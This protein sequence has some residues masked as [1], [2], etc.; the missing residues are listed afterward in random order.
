MHANFII[1]IRKEAG[2]SQ[3]SFGNRIGVNFRTVSKW[4]NGK[5]EPN[6]VHQKAIR[7]VFKKEVSTIESQIK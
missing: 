2:L 3:F 5:H 7:N 4:E 6:F 1:A